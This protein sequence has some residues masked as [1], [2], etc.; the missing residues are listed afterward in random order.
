MTQHPLTVA[1]LTNWEAQVYE[2]LLQIG[3]TTTGPLVNKAKVPQS[4][5]YAILE[6]LSQKGLV[7]HIQ[8]N[9]V[10]H[11]NPAPSSRLLTLYKQKEEELNLA[12]K[13]I[14]QKISEPLSVEVFEGFKA[15][16]VIHA[17]IIETNS[18]EF[19]YG[20][21]KGEAYSDETLAFYNWW[22]E[23][24]RIAGVKDHLLISKTKKQVFE[25]QVKEKYTEATEYVKSKTKYC[26]LTL[27]T[28]T[29]IFGDIVIFYHWQ[30]KP[31]II[32][33]KDKNITKNYQEFFLQL[34][35]KYSK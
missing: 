13:S 4:K 7:T 19:V 23:R 5:I 33:M 9:G 2:A 17:Q 11:F 6:M 26:D 14:S 25:T 15:I 18:P 31:K 3:E 1:G 16:R 30:T 34:W 28:D 12:L 20:Y 32:V 10:K 21:S 22:G 29:L 27:P 24:K 8:K 35:E